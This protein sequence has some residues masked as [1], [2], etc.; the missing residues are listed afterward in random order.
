MGTIRLLEVANTVL[1][2]IGERPELSLNSTRGD[3]VKDCIKQAC[4]DVEILHTWQWLETTIIPSTWAGNTAT[5]IPI[6]RVITVSCGSSLTGYRE[7]QNVTQ[8]V[9][10]R[11]IPRPYVGQVTSPDMY[12][13]QGDSQ[14]KFHPYPNDSASR[15]RIRLYVQLPITVPLLDTDVFVNIPDRYIVLIEKKASYLMALRYLDDATNASYFQQEF[16]QLVQQYRNVERG[17]PVRT[18]TMYRGR[19]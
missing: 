3:R 11:N 5:T 7:I 2:A 4:R 15:G 16:E 1:R 19:R 17:V 18:T 8:Y 13:M 14:F 12:S 9:L 6:Q 10:D